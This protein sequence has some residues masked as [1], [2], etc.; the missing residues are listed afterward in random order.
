MSNSFFLAAAVLSAVTGLAVWSR[1]DRSD[2]CG[3]LAELSAGFLGGG[4]KLG[5]PKRSANDFHLSLMDLL[6]SFGHA[7]AWTSPEW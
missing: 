7:I 5:A 1:V 6:F 2:C 4:E 3:A